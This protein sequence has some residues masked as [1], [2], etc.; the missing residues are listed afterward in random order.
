[1]KSTRYFFIVCITTFLISCNKDDSII[2]LSVHPEDVVH[3]MAG[4]MGASWHSIIKDIPKNNHLYEYP[5][6]DGTT[7]GSAW[8]GNPPLEYEDAWEQICNHAEWLGLNFMRVE[9]S[10]RMY[11]PDRNKFDWENEEMQA[12]FRI[13]DWCEKAGADVF[14]QQMWAYVEWNAIPGVHPLLSAPNSVDD[15]AEGIGTLLDHL[16]NT[17]GYT[18]IKYIS[19]VNEPPGGTWGYWWGFG[20]GTGSVTPAWKRVH[21]EID[22][23]D[24]DVILSGPDWTDMPPFD[25]SKIDFDPYIGSYDIHSYQGIGDKEEAIISDWVDWARKHNKPFLLTEFG[26]M[27]LGWRGDNPGPKS[28]EAALSNAEGIMRGLRQEVDA[29]NRWSFTN[30][31]DLDGQWQLIRTFD[32]E[33]KQYYKS[34]EPE[35]VA[36]YGYGI[37]TRFASKYAE[38]MKYELSNLPDSCH[39]YAGVLRNPGGTITMYLV[40]RDDTDY[41]LK[42]HFEESQESDFYLYQVTEEKILNNKN[43]LNPVSK[44]D[45]E[46]RAQAINIPAK[47]LT[48]ISQLHLTESDKGLV[49]E[50]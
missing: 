2:K 1:M 4:G 38:I 6:H 16:I 33:S 12:L 11:E 31:G 26:N 19:I 25:A 23:R 28:F 29:F 14:L 3:T 21:E 50:N 13:L 5:V 44:V 7:R 17:R 24:L 10:Q 8:G 37:I 46:N 30:R 9:L 47:S 42:L 34:A 43:P 18:C 39:L 35:P 45:L 22:A 27:Q 48:A 32:R 20:D 41:N 49:Y 40:N 36:Y 15:F